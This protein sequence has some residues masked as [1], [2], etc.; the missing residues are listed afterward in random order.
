MKKRLIFMLSILLLIS[1]AFIGCSSSNND[2]YQSEKTNTSESQSNKTYKLK[3]GEL[4]EFNT[5]DNTLIIKAK[6]SPSYS[7]KTTISQNGYNVEDIILNQGGDSFDEIQYWAVADMDDGSE[8][9]VISFTLNKD[10]INAIK[11]KQIVGNQIVDKATDVWI[12]PSLLN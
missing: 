10:Q 5:N 7:N 3:F 4:V 1:F 8:S 2:K 6:I 12:L 9:K 11:N